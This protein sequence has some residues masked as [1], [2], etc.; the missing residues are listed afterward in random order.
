M[1]EKG[2]DKAYRDEF[3]EARLDANDLLLDFYGNEH[4]GHATWT[5]TTNGER[6]FRAWYGIGE[7]RY[8]TE[9]SLPEDLIEA[10]QC[11]I[12]EIETQA[13]LGRLHKGY[14]ER[15]PKVRNDDVMA[16]VY[17]DEHGLND[18]SSS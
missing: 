17:Y 13:A 2:F 10:A 7:L 11:D 9:I 12:W 1:T 4:Y 14:N 18:A 3:R 8:V 6:N 5:G 16:P 15:I